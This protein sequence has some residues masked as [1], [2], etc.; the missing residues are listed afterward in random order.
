MN[1]RETMAALFDRFQSLTQKTMPL[2]EPYT[3]HTRRAYAIN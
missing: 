3:T 2:N 1:S